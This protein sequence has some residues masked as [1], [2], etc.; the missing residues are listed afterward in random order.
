MPSAA[1]RHINQLPAQIKV[2]RPEHI[3]GD[4]DLTKTASLTA[5]HGEHCC[6][7]KGR[8]RITNKEIAAPEWTPPSLTSVSSLRSQVLKKS[9]QLLPCW[10]ADRGLEAQIELEFPTAHPRVEGFNH[11]CAE[12]RQRELGVTCHTELREITA[13]QSDIVDHE[14]TIGPQNQ[15]R[16]LPGLTAIP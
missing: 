14:F 12:A 4:E 15:I 3:V 2:L 1:D 16:F 7:P 6:R 8:E 9:I 13:F 10:G 5:M 11:R